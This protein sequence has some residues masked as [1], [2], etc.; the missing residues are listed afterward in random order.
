MLC[1]SGDV[2]WFGKKE[3]GDAELDE[4]SEVCAQTGQLPVA[5]KRPLAVLDRKQRKKS[6]PDGRR[7]SQRCA[8]CGRLPRIA[9]QAKKDQNRRGTVERRARDPY[10]G[11]T[12]ASRRR[13]RARHESDRV[14]VEPIS[15]AENR[16]L[17]EMA[18][19]AL[20]S[21]AIF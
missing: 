8:A 17:F 11:R 16:S 7:E 12:A 13:R 18:R 19:E 15:A 20:A 3:Q 1:G 6:V 14:L 21:R 5:A 4:R 9:P 2:I 10:R